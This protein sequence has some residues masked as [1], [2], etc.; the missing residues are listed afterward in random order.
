MEA[1][2]ASLV[3]VW[4][5]PVR[6][7]PTLPKN[8]SRRMQMKSR[9]VRPVCPV[10]FSPEGNVP[11]PAARGHYN[12]PSIVEPADRDVFRKRREELAIIAT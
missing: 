8:P 12:H 3:R 1:A 7:G 4:R 11:H 9:P 10:A 6:R 5:R 2:A